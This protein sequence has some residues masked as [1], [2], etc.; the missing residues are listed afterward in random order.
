M[1]YIDEVSGSVEYTWE[2]IVLFVEMVNAKI[3]AESPQ[4]G[5][6]VLAEPRAVDYAAGWRTQPGQLTVLAGGAKTT[7]RSDLDE[8]ISKLSGTIHSASVG[9]VVGGYATKATNYKK[10][11]G[12]SDANA[13]IDRQS[14]VGPGTFNLQYQTGSVSHAGVIFVAEDPT[15]IVLAK[16]VESFEQGLMVVSP[17]SA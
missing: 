17:R 5:G 10:I 11:G 4:F 12:L 2:G 15:A 6:T 1:G 16:L 8:L 7:A 9:P 14:P 3:G 13:R